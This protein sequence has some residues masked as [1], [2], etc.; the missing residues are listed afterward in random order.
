MACALARGRPQ[1]LALIRT[2]RDAEL[3]DG[4]LVRR[5]QL[6]TLAALDAGR[7][8]LDRFITDT[9]AP[10]RA[11]DLKPATRAFYANLYSAHNAPTFATVALR[12]ISSQRVASWQATA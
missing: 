7:M 3:F 12:E 2:R 1:P 8:T 5:R 4:D 9:W 6:G 11:A 10:Q